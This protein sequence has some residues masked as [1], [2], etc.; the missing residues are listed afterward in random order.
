VLIALRVPPVAGALEGTLA[1]ITAGGFPYRTDPGVWPGD[2]WV[3]AEIP[4]QPD[5]LRRA[6]GVLDGLN[7]TLMLDASM[8][9]EHVPSVYELSSAGRLRYVPEPQ[10]REWWQTYRDN[11]NEGEGDCEDLASHQSQWNTLFGG[12]PSFTDTYR[13]GPNIYH[14]I[15]RRLPDRTKEDP[16]MPLGLWW[17]RLL[18]QPNV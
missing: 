12:V 2:T 14:A 15:V 7:R 10:G 13:S 4:N 16:S 18:R 1:G 3:R 8:R 17:R 6:L 5:H 9:G 11:I